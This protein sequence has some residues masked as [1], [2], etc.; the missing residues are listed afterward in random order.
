MHMVT[1]LFEGGAD[2]ADA[3]DAADG[4]VGLFEGR[5]GRVHVCFFACVSFHEC[6]MP[7]S[8]SAVGPW[9]WI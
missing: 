4:E 5:T 3:G 7:A 8:V 1:F 6:R 9:S 2:A